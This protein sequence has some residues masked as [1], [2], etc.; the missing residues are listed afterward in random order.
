V[1]AKKKRFAKSRFVSVPAKKKRFAKS[2][3]SKT[4]LQAVLYLCRQKRNDLQNRF[5]VKQL[6]QAVF[7][8]SLCFAS[9]SG[10]GEG[11]S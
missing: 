11:L 7:Y 2:F 5:T 3:Y 10:T 4:A 9:R 6:L 8:F 1:P